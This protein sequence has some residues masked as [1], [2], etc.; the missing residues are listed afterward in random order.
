MNVSLSIVFFFFF[1]LSFEKC[2]FFNSSNSKVLHVPDNYSRYLP[3]PENV[4]P[5]SYFVRPGMKLFS[6]VFCFLLCICNILQT[7]KCHCTVTS[8]NLYFVETKSQ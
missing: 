1:S 3:Y 8:L 2:I 4:K 5:N 6:P 7:E